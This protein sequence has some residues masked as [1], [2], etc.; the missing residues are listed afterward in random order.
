MEL[1]D[2]YDKQIHSQTEC[3]FII[4]NNKAE[5]NQIKVR[6]VGLLEINH[7]H[8]RSEFFI[9]IDPAY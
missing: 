5:N 6:L 8:K 2:L 4:K 1:L 3:R 7:L 9:V